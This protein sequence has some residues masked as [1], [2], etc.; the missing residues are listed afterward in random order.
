MLAV[1]GRC[2]STAR[3]QI[4]PRSGGLF[5]GSRDWSGGKAPPDPRVGNGE[6]KVGKQL[7][8][9]VVRAAT[10]PVTDAMSPSAVVPVA[11]FRVCVFDVA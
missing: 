1:R 10:P 8:S 4:Q 3:V 11:G 6:S 5:N 9:I 7:S 2:S